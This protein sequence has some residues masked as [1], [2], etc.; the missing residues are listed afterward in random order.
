[1]KIN[2][3][4][5]GVYKDVATSRDR[6]LKGPA[7][8]L[9]KLGISANILSF[10]RLVLAIPMFFLVGVAPVGALLLLVVNY[11][12]LDAIDGVVARQSGKVNLQ[13]RA[14]DVSIDNFYVVPLVLALIFFNY[15]NAFWASFYLV[16]LLI[17]YF[18]N[19]VRFGIKVGE[20]P[21]FYSKFAVYF[22]FFVW[23]FWSLNFFDFVFIFFALY[24]MAM[25]IV[26]VIKIYHGK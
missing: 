25:N 24:L 11:Y 8:I 6:I 14:L 4:A 21:F 13:G 10:S 26:S 3:W 23:T 15:V 2:K 17:D 18:A 7:S 22:A 16:N 12:V 9:I 20:F 1:M 5:L 19:Y